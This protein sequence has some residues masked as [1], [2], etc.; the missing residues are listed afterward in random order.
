M[1]GDK[2][3]SVAALLTAA[4]ATNAPKF[5]TAIEEEFR[6]L[7]ALGN[8][9]RIRHSETDKEPV[10]SRLEAEYL[11]QRMFSLLRYILLQTGRVRLS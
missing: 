4:A 3:T 7:T 10:S 11:F 1:S 9:L 2:K 5:N 6:A 8:S